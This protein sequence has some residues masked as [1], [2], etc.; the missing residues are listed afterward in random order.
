MSKHKKSCPECG[1]PMYKT[2]QVCRVC[3]NK[4]IAKPEHYIT[5]ICPVCSKSFTVHKVHIDRGQGK[6]C[7][8]SCARSGSPTKKKTSVFVTCAHCGTS[9]RKHKSEI[10][11]MTG[12]LHFCSTECWYSH[13]QRENHYLWAGGQNER[14]NPE[15]L[16][17]RKLV[18]NRDKGYCR[19]CHGQDR[20]EAHHIKRFT[21]YPDLRWE[22]D[23]GVTLCRNC[24][25]K[26]R[27]REEEYEEI[28]SLMASVPVTV[29]NV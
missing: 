9:Y 13:N 23:N 18:L 14:V 25:V 27:H 17:W 20:L 5:N 8:H 29:W 10:R 22:V 6:Y 19:L 1:Q 28:F 16:Q 4:K 11:K 24:H 3:Y 2:S 26:F 15:Y 7:S 12:G 21:L